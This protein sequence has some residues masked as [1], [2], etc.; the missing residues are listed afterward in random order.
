MPPKTTTRGPEIRS[1][2]L[3]LLDAASLM[4]AVAIA[5]A[6]RFDGFHLAIA[7][8][9]TAIAFAFT[10]TPVA[11]T[12]FVLSGLYRRIWSFASVAEVER[13]ALGVSIAAVCSAIVGLVLLPVSGLTP[14]RVPLS[15]V[16]LYAL[17]SGAFIVAPRLFFRVRTWHGRRRRREDDMRA[18]IVGAGAAGHMI[19]KELLTNHELGLYPVAFI[20][21]D[22]RKNKLRLHEIPVVGTIADIG[23]VAHEQ[24]VGAIVIAMPSAPGSVIR[25]IVQ[26][27]A[28]AGLK[29]RTLPPLSDVLS[30]RASP[31]SL[32]D[33]QI[34]DLLRRDPVQTDL[35]AVRNLAKGRTVLITGAGG[36]IGSEL[37]RQLARL[38]PAC[39]VILGHGENSIFDIQA[40]LLATFPKLNLLPVI[41]DVRDRQRINGIFDDLRPY[42]VFHAAAHK[43][44][45]LMEEN[46]VEAITNN[47]HGTTNVVNAAIDAGVE[48]FVLIS[49]DKAVRPTSIMGATKRLAERVVQHAAVA[50]GRNFV[51]VRFGNVLGSRGSVV[52][53]FFRQIRAGGPVMVTHPEMRRYFMT[54]PESVQL[55]LQAGTLGMGGEVFVLDMGEPVKIVDLASDL[56]R[57]CGYEPG[58]DIDIQ[59]TGIRPGEKLYEE[60]FFHEEHALPTTHPKLLRAKKAGMP[61]G[62]MRRIERLVVAAE[63]ADDNELRDMLVTLVPDFQ[64]EATASD[65]T[66]RD[67]IQLRRT[68]DFRANTAS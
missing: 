67:V 34:E 45:P 4:V 47:V 21:D 18:I 32:R 46:V 51:S 52:P 36:S 15:V 29:T 38:E 11:L 66:A 3:L 37:C 25:R 13:M 60:M 59:F 6:L 30:G 62:L 8:R 1:R 65:Y 10:A 39:L 31:S 57:L 16:A 23:R 35:A 22:P 24:D 44:V 19:A 26:A 9:T 43:H 48:H 7:D 28:D 58:K 50:H 68:G 64:R 2:Y 5:Y 17:L 27:A 20:D 54:I 41:A 42:A 33:V 40:E 55:V 49:T 61:E 63:T 53:T 14:V 56:I 12:V